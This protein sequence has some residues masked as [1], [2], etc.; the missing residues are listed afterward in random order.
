MTNALKSNGD[1]RTD[2]ETQRPFVF[3]TP[4]P[5]RTRQWLRRG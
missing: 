4:R 5:P 3:S 2:R 1:G